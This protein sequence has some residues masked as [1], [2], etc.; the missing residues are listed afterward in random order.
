MGGEDFG[1]GTNPLT[2]NR[3]I[4]VPVCITDANPISNITSK[5]PGILRAAV[6]AAFLFVAVV[7]VAHKDA[8]DA[9]DA[10]DT[11]DKHKRKS[12]IGTIPPGWRVSVCACVC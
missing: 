11:D 1:S 4:F 8:D 9:N 7:R 10:D 12:T 5:K 3:E 6:V 2:T